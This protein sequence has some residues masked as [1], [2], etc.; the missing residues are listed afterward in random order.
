MPD[1]DA[2]EYAYWELRDNVASLVASVA[3]VAQAAAT[4]QSK[5][6]QLDDEEQA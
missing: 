2:L 5:L 3:D 6:E 4:I 1:P